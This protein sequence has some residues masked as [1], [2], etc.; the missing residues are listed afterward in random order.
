MTDSK[1]NLDRQW[2][3]MLKPFAVPRPLAET[4]FTQLVAAY[5][6]SGRF[7]HN[8]SHI[9]DVLTTIGRLMGNTR[10]PALH[11]AAWFHDAVYDTRATDNEEKSAVL[12]ATRLIEM[13]IPDSIAAATEHLILLTKNHVVDA[14]D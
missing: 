7:Y 2:L 14:E 3:E 1:V 13:H 10:H 8:L 11:F 12:A 4:T 6:E 9:E 5:S